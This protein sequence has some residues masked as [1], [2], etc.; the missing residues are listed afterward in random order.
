M[1]FRSPVAYLPE[2]TTYCLMHISFYPNDQKQKKEYVELLH[3]VVPTFPENN[4][5]IEH[6][7]HGKAVYAAKRAVSTLQALTQDQGKFPFVREEHINYSTRRCLWRMKPLALWSLLIA[8]VALANMIGI[9]VPTW[10]DFTALGWWPPIKTELLK[11]TTATPLLQIS[12][13][14]CLVLLFLWVRTVKR[15]WVWRAGLIYAES[16]LSALHILEREIDNKGQE[17]R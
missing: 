12:L 5:D 16:L 7:S 10:A 15:G 4:W 17:N 14:L 11:T 3:K 13:L 9:H 8:I 6:E 2:P 1:L